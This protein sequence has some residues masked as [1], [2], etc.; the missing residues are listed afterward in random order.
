MFQRYAKFSNIFSTSSPGHIFAT[1]VRRKRVF[2]KL[3][4][5]R[6]WYFLQNQLWWTKFSGVYLNHDWW[7][8]FPDIQLKPEAAVY[9]RTR[10]RLLWRVLKNSQKNTHA[11]VFATL[12]KKKDP[13]QVFSCKF[14]QIIKST[15]HFRA[16]APGEY[17]FVSYVNLNRKILPSALVSSV[18]L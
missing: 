6:G 3:L 16:T 11:W 15:F 14:C 8:N 17:P 18:F 10:K 9:R 12:F 7:S 1:T 13:L 5:G 2:L 4:W